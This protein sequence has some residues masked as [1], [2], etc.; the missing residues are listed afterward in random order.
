MDGIS[1]C[2]GHGRRLNLFRRKM[3]GIE[4]ERYEAKGVNQI[5][6]QGKSSPEFSNALQDFNHDG[7]LVHEGMISTFDD[8]HVTPILAHCT[9]HPSHR[10]LC[11]LLVSVTVPHPN[12]VRVVGI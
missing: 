1:A 6:W 10:V 11:N 9:F 7:A 2:G 8:L 5:K 12:F 3:N 4:R